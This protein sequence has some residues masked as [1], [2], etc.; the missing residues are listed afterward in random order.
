MQSHGDRH[1]TEIA[2]LAGKRLVLASEVPTGRS[3]NDTLLKDLTG[4]EK[5]TARRMHKDE[6]S[7]TPCGTVI[8]TANTLPSFPGAQEAMYR[9]ILLVPMLRQF[10]NDEQ[11]P[12]LAAKLY[13][14]EGPAILGWL[15]EGARKF[16]VDGGG[17]SG[18]RIPNSIIDAT[19]TYFEEED[20]I[21]QFLKDVQNRAGSL[22]NWSEGTFISHAM[23]LTEF[24]QWTKDNGYMSWTM[25][26][27]TKA[28]SE[29][30]GRYGL[31]ASR[32][33]SARG[34]RVDRLLA[35]PTEAWQSRRAIL[36]AL[37][38]RAALKS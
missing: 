28:I 17:V 9:R 12:N 29:N 38:G 30:A 33:K 7:F 31:S 13:A 36:A 35:G 16:L 21:L 15:I 20:I 24:S 3:W 6:F 34:F 10:S 1:P 8:F 14:E 32:T 19:R 2:S 11:D 22:N 18:L 5:M 25:R 27:L 23:L 37:P 26:S 4:G